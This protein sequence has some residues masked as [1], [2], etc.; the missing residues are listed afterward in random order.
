MEKA[1][2][3]SLMDSAWLSID[4]NKAE[5]G[6]DFCIAAK[7]S[8]ASFSMNTSM[9]LSRPNNPNNF[10]GCGYVGNDQLVHYLFRNGI[11]TG[12]QADDF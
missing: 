2:V 4:T 12:K 7:V 11:V 10:L 8:G 3:I 5:P 6:N 1:R 9:E